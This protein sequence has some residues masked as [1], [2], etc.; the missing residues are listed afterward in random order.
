MKKVLS[1]GLAPGI[2]V[3]R[4]MSRSACRKAALHTRPETRI[5]LRTPASECGVLLGVKAGRRQRLYSNHEEHRLYVAPPRSWKTASCGNDVIDAPGAALVTSTKADVYRLTMPFR[6]HHGPIRALSP[7]GMGGVESNLSWSPVAGCDDPDTAILRA[8]YLLSGSASAGKGEEAEFWS[9]NTHRVLRCLLHAAA[10]EGGD[11]RMVLDWAQDLTVTKPVDVLRDNPGATMGWADALSSVVEAPGMEKTRG[12]IS[13]T[14]TLAFEFMSS[15]ALAA[16]ACPTKGEHLDIEGFIRARGTLYLLGSDKKRGGLGPLFAALTGAIYETA[17]H[18]A[19]GNPTGRLD[20]PMQ[21]VLDEAYSI[22]RVPLPQWTSDAGGRGISMTICLQAFDQ[23]DDGWGKEA[24]R[25]IR[26]NCA[27][28]MIGGGVAVSHHLEELSKLVGDRYE[29]NRS[30]SEDR[31][32]DSA[33]KV[34]VFTVA[35]LREL[36]PF[37][38][39]A[40]HRNT[41]AVLVRIVPVWNRKPPKRVT[42]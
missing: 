3:T 8:G 38:A 27:V 28:T 5:G 19:D 2:E 32:T 21:F 9:G 24:A 17:K 23:L 29:R 6:V 7:E 15:P 31:T 1:R 30:H 34:P 40:L 11:L 26:T 20:P 4:T 22:C 10:L 12:S 33:S 16:A 42:A 35:E 37:T 41:G 25:I 39:L 13:I 36:G 14:L 18:I